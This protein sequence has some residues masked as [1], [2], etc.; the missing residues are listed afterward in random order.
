[1]EDKSGPALIK[2]IEEK[3]WDMHE[4]RIVSDDVEPIRE[5]VKFWSDVKK[6]SLILTT[7]GTGFGVRD[8]TPEVSV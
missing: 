8:V 3:G 6:V 5:I 7:G 4:H 1:M 2:S